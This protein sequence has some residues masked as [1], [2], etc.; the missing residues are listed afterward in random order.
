MLRKIN[1]IDEHDI[2]NKKVCIKHIPLLQQKQLK[3]C[4]QQARK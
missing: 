3:G 1:I 2:K 4:V